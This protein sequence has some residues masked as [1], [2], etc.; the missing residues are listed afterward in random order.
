MLVIW[1][2]FV[3]SGKVFDASTSSETAKLQIQITKEIHWRSKIAFWA[4][5]NGIARNLIGVYVYVTEWEIHW[6]GVDRG[7]GVVIPK[8]SKKRARFAI[9][10]SPVQ[11]YVSGTNQ[12][13]DAGKPKGVSNSCKLPRWT[14]K[15]TFPAV[16]SHFGIHLRYALYAYVA[17]CSICAW[18]WSSPKSQ[19]KA[20]LLQIWIL[21]D[22]S[23]WNWSNR[24]SELV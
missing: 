7:C 16:L 19:Q 24:V 18:D 4:D 15:R 20:D 21:F 12:W 17:D 13:I 23:D 1:Y 6:R 14:R 10:P 2:T 22:P 8:I 5:K 3:F 11:T 9:Q